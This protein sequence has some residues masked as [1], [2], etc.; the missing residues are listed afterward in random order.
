MYDRV[1][2]Q[3]STISKELREKYCDSGKMGMID[4]ED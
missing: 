1:V 3:N 4:M 2:G